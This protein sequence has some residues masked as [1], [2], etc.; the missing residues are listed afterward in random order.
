MW[1]NECWKMST[2]VNQRPSRF[3]WR[4]YTYKHKTIGPPSRR[5]VKWSRRKK[6]KDN[7]KTALIVANSFCRQGSP[8]AL[9]LPII[10]ATI[11][12]IGYVYLISWFLVT[13]LYIMCK[14]C[15][16]NNILS[17]NNE[18]IDL[19]G[20]SVGIVLLPLVGGLDLLIVNLCPPVRLL[21]LDLEVQ[22]QCD[23]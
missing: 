19:V 13:Y 8:R 1:G 9:L 18:L 6:E 12:D 10:V 16:Y 20:L 23:Q 5:R 7:E 21:L 11:P 3:S 14:Y 15:M 22:Q 17:I 4:I 2:C